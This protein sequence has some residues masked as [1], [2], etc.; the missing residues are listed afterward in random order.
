MRPRGAGWSLLGLCFVLFLRA[1]WGGDGVF[2][3]GGKGRRI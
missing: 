2:F 1:G 3:G